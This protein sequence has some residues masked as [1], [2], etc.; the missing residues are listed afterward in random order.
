MRYADLIPEQ[1][2]FAR[3]LLRDLEAD[4]V[5]EGFSHSLGHAHRPLHEALTVWKRERNLTA[6]RLRVIRGTPPLNKTS[7]RWY[8]M[9]EGEVRYMGAQDEA[10]ARYLFAERPGWAEKAHLSSMTPAELR[11]LSPLWASDDPTEPDG[12]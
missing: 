5:C 9:I 1:R 4:L 12:E 11:Y 3:E 2:A 8:A 6:R 10:M 7:T